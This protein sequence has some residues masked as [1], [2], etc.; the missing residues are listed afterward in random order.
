MAYWDA[1]DSFYILLRRWLAAVREHYSLTG[2]EP[3]KT[4]R[5][6]D[7]E[8]NL[9]AKILRSYGEAFGFASDHA[10]GYR[11]NDTQ[12]DMLRKILGT[13]REGTVGLPTGSAYEWR[14]LDSDR[15]LLAKILRNRCSEAGNTNPQNDFMPLDSEMACLRKIVGIY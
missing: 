11:F 9:L 10:L 4:W 6:L 2:T 12:N 14:T 13:F 15:D 8:N 5:P 3:D 7:S 1:Q